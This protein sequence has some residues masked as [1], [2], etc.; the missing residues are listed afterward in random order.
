MSYNLILTNTAIQDINKIAHQIAIRSKSIETAKKFAYELKDKCNTL[1]DFPNRG[2]FPRDYMLKSIGY[3]FISHK[4]YL[5]FYLVDEKNTTVHIVA[6]FNAKQDYF[7][8]MK[9]FT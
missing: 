5:I 9:P 6:V 4:D 3:R 1:A 2:S 7:H 8:M